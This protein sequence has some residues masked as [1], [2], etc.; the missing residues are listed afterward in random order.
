MIESA[1]ARA[2]DVHMQAIVGSAAV[3]AT[4]EA[5]TQKVA[6]HPPRLRDAVEDE[7]WKAAAAWILRCAQERRHLARCDKA[8]AGHRRPVGVV[9]ELIKA[10]RLEATLEPDVLARG[11]HDA[12]GG[13]A[14]EAPLR[15]RNE[16]VL[17]I[18]PVA[19]EK[20]RVE[21]ST[22][23]GR[24]RPMYAVGEKAGRLALVWPHLDHGLAAEGCITL[25]GRRC[26][27]A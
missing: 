14:C 17:T 22:G 27:K 19:H 11:L 10:P 25:E 16:R 13:L 23:R 24:Q 18:L 6:L 26:G 21:L 1:A 20:T 15:A 5:E 2:R 7:G 3:F 8:E 12:R 9:D 4:I